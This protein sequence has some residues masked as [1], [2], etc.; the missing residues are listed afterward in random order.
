MKVWSTQE[1]PKL[2][3]TEANLD[4][5]NVFYCGVDPNPES[6]S[7]LKLTVKK[8]RPNS[9]SADKINT[10]SYQHLHSGRNQ[11]LVTSKNKPHPPLSFIFKN[12]IFFMT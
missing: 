6:L 7:L 12:Y 5:A 8:W 10:G 4:E 1:N 3:K 9:N 11:T 2:R